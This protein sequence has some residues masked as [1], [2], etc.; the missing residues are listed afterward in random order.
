MGTTAIETVAVLWVV[1]FRVSEK[2]CL[3]VRNTSIVIAPP[4]FVGGIVAFTPP[5]S[6][7]RSF[8]KTQ[9]PGPLLTVIVPVAAWV[10][11][12]NV[13]RS[14]GSYRQRVWRGRAT[15]RTT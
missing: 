5:A 1:S 10:H 7:I 12:S 4:D 9:Y 15:L 2:P 11:I 3:N 8:T 14:G 13:R 6:R